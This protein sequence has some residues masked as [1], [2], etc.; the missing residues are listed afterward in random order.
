MDAFLEIHHRAGGLGLAPRVPG[1]VGAVPATHG[2]RVVGGDP[3]E[4]TPVAKVMATFQADAVLGHLVIADRAFHLVF[5][6]RIKYIAY[7][8]GVD[9]R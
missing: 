6:V 1:K 3:S 7:K 9:D 5:D 4:G 2:T 8:V